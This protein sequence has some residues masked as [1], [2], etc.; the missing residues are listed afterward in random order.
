MVLAFLFTGVYNLQ[1]QNVSVENDGVYD[2]QA[3]GSSVKLRSR[4]AFL[5]VLGKT[6]VFCLLL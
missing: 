2:C 4:K 6:V 5:N 1:I 3:L